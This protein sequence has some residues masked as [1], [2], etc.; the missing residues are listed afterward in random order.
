MKLRSSILLLLLLPFL[1]VACNFSLAEDITPPPNYQPPTPAP[2]LGALYPSAAPNA[3]AGAEIYAQKCAACHGEQGMGDGAQAAQLPVNVPPLGVADIARKASPAQWFTIVS[4][5]NIQ[6]FMPG[7]T[8]LTDQQRWD[9][10]AYAYTLSLNPAQGE[11]LY[12]STCAQCHGADGAALSNANLQDQQTLAALSQQDLVSLIQKGIPPQMP[13]SGLAEEEAYAVADYVRA[14]TFAPAPALAATA[15]PQP[16]TPAAEETPA[17]ES[18]AAEPTQ[19]PS[20]VTFSGTV[21]NL[22]T[23]IL[24]EGLTVTLRA[25]DHDM[26]TGSF[27][28]AFHQ[29][30]KIENGAFRFTGIE[31]VAGQLYIAEVSYLTVPYQTEPLTVEEGQTELSFPTLSVFETV[32]DTA[33]LEMQQIHFFFDT[34]SNGQIPVSVVYAFANGSP[35]S[36]LVETDGTTIPFITVPAGAQNVSF[37]DAGM[38]GQFL[39]AETGFVIPPSM[40]QYGIVALFTLPYDKEVEVRQDFVLNVTSGTIIVPEGMKAEG[41][42]LT[43]GELRPMGENGNFQTSTFATAN[44]QVTFVV[45]GAPK[46]A[47]SSSAAGVDNTQAIIIGVGALGFALLGVGI[48][49]Y[50]R[51]R[52]RAALE[53]EQDE[54]DEDD[55]E[56][57]EGEILDAIIAL[58][59][60]FRAGKIKQEAYQARRADLKE[61]LRK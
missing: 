52:R 3:A 12:Q 53:E 41:E 1:L 22:S 59:D 15:T 7:F 33:T 37:E 25:F 21:S 27:A 48:A 55:E 45:S 38:G 9:V 35:N 8:S 16:A 11:A 18:A 2:T 23:G 30:S 4:Q 24:P 10:V 40:Q 17:T 56:T 47:D 58:D 39:P 36:V 31:P 61:K 5:G 20:G 32:T 60:Q 34:P 44:R 26:T 46:N 28:E 42:G 6:N 57:D 51:D 19:A 14:F 49:F 43:T 29:E 13:A 50:L 54:E